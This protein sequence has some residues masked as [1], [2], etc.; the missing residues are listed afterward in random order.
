MAKRRMESVDFTPNNDRV[1]FTVK[2]RSVITKEVLHSAENWWTGSRKGFSIQISYRKDFPEDQKVRW[3]VCI[4]RKWKEG[5][6]S[7]IFDAMQSV[8][9]KIANRDWDERK[10][11]MEEGKE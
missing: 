10:E 8:E 3:R 7:T 1:L 11:R 4:N 9:S 2:D 6:T 5:T